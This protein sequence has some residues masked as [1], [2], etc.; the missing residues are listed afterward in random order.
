MTEKSAVINE[1][2]IGYFDAIC[3]LQ[4]HF[5]RLKEDFIHLDVFSE[6]QDDLFID[7]RKS[8]YQ[9]LSSICKIANSTLEIF[10]K[11]C[12]INSLTYKDE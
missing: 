1:A 2:Y 3:K 9:Y 5:S 8:Y 6:R 7:Y 10:E 4:D 11:T 12:D